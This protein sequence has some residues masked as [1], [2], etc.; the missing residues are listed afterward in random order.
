MGGLK[1]SLSIEIALDR[2]PEQKYF[3]VR[4]EKGEKVKLPIYTGNDD[5]SGE[6]KVELKD[7]K[8]Y[9]HL[10][11]KVMLIGYLCTLD[12]MQKYSATRISLPSST[13][14]PSSYSPQG[15]SLKIN[16]SSS[17]FPVSKKSMR[18]LMASQEEFG[19][20]SEQL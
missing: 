4:G 6:V 14:Y 1:G 12:L 16:H 17:N 2:K 18:H 3:K 9:E 15:Y 19:T 20:S 5:I 10:G 11:V 13:L 7:T 8:K